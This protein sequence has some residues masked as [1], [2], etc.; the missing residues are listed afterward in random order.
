MMDA[1]IIHAIE[2]THGRFMQYYNLN[3]AGLS[4]K[5]LFADTKDV[6]LWMPDKNIDA[7]GLK[8]IDDTLSSISAQRAKGGRKRDIHLTHCP[9]F[10]ISDDKK[11]AYGTWDTYSFD[12]KPG[13]DGKWAVEF[14]TSRMDAS[15]I[16]QGGTWKYRNLDWYEIVSFM[17]WK[18]LAKD[19]VHADAASLPLPPEPTGVKSTKDYLEIQK[20]QARFSHDNRRNAMGLFADRD[21]ITFRMANLFEGT[22]KGREK[23]REQ[24]RRLDE[25]EALNGGN[26]LC[27]PLITAPVIEIGTDRRTACGT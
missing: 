12:I 14:Y 22:V 5:Q 25:M 20:L 7:V 21:D 9:V 15:F 2:N 23:I 10:K 11:T 18:A 16:R 27:V 26:Y 6:R 1:K 8:A 17:P 4:A 24:L 13:A 19:D 3:K